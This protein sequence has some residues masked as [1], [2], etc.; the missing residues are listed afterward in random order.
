MHPQ[1]SVALAKVMMI[2][3]SMLTE[4]SPVKPSVIHLNAVLKM[5]A[6]AQNIDAMLAIAADMPKRGVGSPNNLSYTTI[7]NALRL[8]AVGDLRSTLTPMQKRQNIQKVLL[9]AR[10]MWA[11]I[12]ERWT[13]G[14]IWIDE[15]LVCAMGR[16]LLVGG[17][18][19]RDDILSLIEQT[20]N[21]P[22]QVPRLGTEARRKIDPRAH[23]PQVPSQ[24][25][26]K[27]AS[28]P[29]HQ[30]GL[31]EN[32]Q[33][34]ARRIHDKELAVAAVDQFQP[35]KPPARS[36]AG[37]G[38]YA[39][40]GQNSL[41]LVLQ[42]VLDTK[43]KEP[44]YKYWQ[45]FT[46]EHN[47]K[48]DQ[49]NF[50]AYLRILRVARASNETVNFLLKVPMQDLRHTAFRIAMATCRRD[51]LNK[52]AFANAGKLLDLMQS[53]LREP[54]IAFLEGYLELAIAAPAYSKKLDS[55]GRNIASKVE[56]G[57]QILRA[58][59]RLNP[60]FVNLK[61]I[62]HFEDPDLK[63]KSPTERTEFVD[64]ILSLTKKM[65]S[66]YEL[67]LNKGMVHRHFYSS[68]KSQ[69]SKLA[70][71]V[72]RHKHLKAQSHSKQQKPDP[73]A[74]DVMKWSGD[75]LAVLA[76]SEPISHPQI[77]YQE[78]SEL[79]PHNS[80]LKTMKHPQKHLQSQIP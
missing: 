26:D 80:P 73:D 65:I 60:S 64:C 33:L 9:D 8:Y 66:S 30:P 43:L 45:I 16:L 17:L 63:R 68:L 47:V 76:K 54:D 20:M 49:A 52:S 4:K 74:D 57:K 70:A 55:G 46:T 37:R 72:T 28:S 62:L 10:R 31:D 78:P 35:V 11:D 23:E 12:R 21:I 2:Y 38:G 40:P 44:A 61:A 48:P 69:Q 3:H 77:S 42:V 29:E 56:Q 25:S 32:D 13:Q 7:F 18:Q 59:D 27:G 15:E 6:R 53:A 22:R 36:G 75:T 58:L 41:S 34:P 14:D 24:D 1:P 19:D 67:L 39:T 71:F 50:H 51:K 5:C 79:T